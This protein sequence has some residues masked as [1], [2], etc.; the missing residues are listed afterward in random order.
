[1]NGEGMTPQVK[2]R[3]FE[4]F[5]T[6]KDAGRGTGLGLSVVYGFVTQSQG[7]IDIESTPGEGTTVTL[8]LPRQVDSPEESLAPASARGTAPAPVPAATA[9]GARLPTGLRVL[10][11]ED[12][13]EVRQVAATYLRGMGCTVLP[14]ASGEEAWTLLERQG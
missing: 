6:T 10:L 13:A 12:D 2:A 4:P 5:F 7:A 9:D 14:A 3:V 11:V 1:D 8:Y